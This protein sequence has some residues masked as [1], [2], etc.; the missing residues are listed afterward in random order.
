MLE[1]WAEVSGHFSAWSQSAE[2][3]FNRFE[4]RE[5]GAVALT[6]AITPHKWTP[7]INSFSDTFS[8]SHSDNERTALAA[9]EKPDL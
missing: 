9:N 2:K 6:L 3:R 1:F 5:P 8:D 7:E 4:W